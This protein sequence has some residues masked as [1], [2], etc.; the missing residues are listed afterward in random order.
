MA[1]PDR[2]YGVGQDCP[3]HLLGRPLIPEL[4][5]RAIDIPEYWPPMSVDR[6]VLANIV[7]YCLAVREAIPPAYTE[8]IARQIPVNRELPGGGKSEMPA[9][10]IGNPPV[11]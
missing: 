4:Y 9:N 6:E 7:D 2:Y 8:L 3:E 1:K 10:R 11:A 5:I